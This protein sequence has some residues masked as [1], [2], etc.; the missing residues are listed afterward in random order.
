MTKNSCDVPRKKVKRLTEPRTWPAVAARVVFHG[1]GP[2]DDGQARAG[3]VSRRQV[4][5]AAELEAVGPLV[6][7]ALLLDP[8]Q[9]GRR[10][11]EIGQGRS[12]LRS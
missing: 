8:G 1:I 9:L 12:L 2:D 4:E 11:L 7:D 3:L 6:G 10:V 5:R